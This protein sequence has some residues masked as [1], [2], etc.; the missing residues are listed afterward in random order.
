M[1]LLRWFVIYMS[2]AL[3]LL[4]TTLHA[5]E[6]RFTVFLRDVSGAGVVAATV[7]INNTDGEIIV[8]ATTDANG[9]AFFPIIEAT[10]IHVLVHGFLSDGTLLRQLG[11]DADGIAF[12]NDSP[13]LTLDLRVEPDGSVL[14]DPSTMIALDT[15]NVVDTSPIPEASASGSVTESTA[16]V[17][18]NE[19]PSQ[20]VTPVNFTTETSAEET[21]P[22]ATVLVVVAFLVIATSLGVALWM[23]RQGTL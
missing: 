6:Q 19:N 4:P 1:L 9:A 15:A 7:Q 22:V 17:I 21:D 16:V 3:L 20:Q 10:T 5:Q 23:R 12:I 13:N 8:T 14:P 18:T 2:V 11:D